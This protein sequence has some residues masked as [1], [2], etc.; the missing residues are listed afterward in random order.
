MWLKDKIN[1]GDL[2]LCG[3][4]TGQVVAISFTQSQVGD[5]RKAPL[6]KVQWILNGWTSWLEV[7]EFILW[8]RRR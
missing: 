4:H 7:D 8:R 5:G 2:V 6:Y 1:V 3:R